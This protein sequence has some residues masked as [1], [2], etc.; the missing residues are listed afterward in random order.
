MSFGR[1]LRP[2]QLKLRHELRH[3][4]ARLGIRQVAVRCAQ[5]VHEVFRLGGRGDD[6]RAGRVGNQEEVRDP[7]PDDKRRR[8]RRNGSGR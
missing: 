4:A 8:E 1:V 6:T 5:V 2:R 3:P 7:N